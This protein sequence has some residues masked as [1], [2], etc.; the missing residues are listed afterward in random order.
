MIRCQGLV[1]VYPDGT[2]AI[3]GIDLEIGAGE[4]VALTGPNGSGK[5]TLIRHW[6][7]LL[8]PTEGTVEIEGHP[9]DRRHVADLARTVGLVFQDPSTQLFAATCRAEVAFGVRNAG[10]RGREL[11]TVVDQSLEM[12]GLLGRATTNPYDLGP[13][14]RRL[15]TIAS[16]LAMR[17]KVIVLDEPTIGLDSAEIELLARIVEAASRRSQTVVAITHEQRFAAAFDRVVRI[18]RGRV[19]GDDAR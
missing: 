19:V 11:A 6:N 2:R 16:V 8:R 12:V 1:H 9:T 10:L 4:R 7:G 17:P 18:D 5:T 13:S 15:L 3:D 14:K